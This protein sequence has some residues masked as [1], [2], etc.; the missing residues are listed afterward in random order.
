VRTLAFL[1]LA[2]ANIALIFVNRTFTSSLRAAFGRPNRMLAWGL[3]IAVTL[4]GTILWWPALRNFFGLGPLRAADLLL[5]LGAALGLLLT[6]ELTK[7]AWRRR[8]TA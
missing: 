8:L 1:T 3:G 2:A 7:L 5:C 4:L 6:L